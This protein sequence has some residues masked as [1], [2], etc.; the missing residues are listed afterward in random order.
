MGIMTKRFSKILITGG[1]GFIGSHIVD[2]ML[3]EGSEVTVLDDLSSGQLEN[4]TQCLDNKHFHFMKGDVRDW[5]F[6]KRTV[7]DFDAVFHEAALVSVARSIEDPLLTN[8]INVDGTLNVLKVA[9]DSGVKRLVFASSAAVYGDARS[10][11]ISED[12]ELNPLSPYGLSKS[13]GELY[14]KYFYDVYGLET[15]SLRYFNVFGPRQTLN[16][17]SQYSGVISVF[18]DRLSDNLSPTIFGDGEQTRDFVFVEDV[19]EANMLAL[20]RKQVSGEVLN[21][22]SGRSVSINQV[23]E[24]LKIILNKRD[25]KNNYDRPR[26]TDIRDSCADISKAQTVL[27][28]RPR[29]AFDQS[30]KRLAQWYMARRSCHAEAWATAKKL[31]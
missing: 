27:G 28:Y 17:E 26:P 30:I 3:D 25:L 2:R 23:A 1:A 5:N 19:V 15:V 24:T 21:I 6:V 12:H 18:L 16:P 9:S 14:A 20:T 10:K 4:L 8:Q 22:G 7:R 29:V 11:K 13:V 31:N